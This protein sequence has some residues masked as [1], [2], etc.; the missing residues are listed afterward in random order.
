MEG[1]FGNRFDEQT[2]RIASISILATYPRYGPLRR[3]YGS[4]WVGCSAARWLPIEWRSESKTSI[5]AL[6]SGQCHIG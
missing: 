3:P 5:S 4:E 6:Y 2:T 1:N